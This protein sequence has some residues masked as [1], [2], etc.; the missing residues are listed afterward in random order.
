MQIAKPSKD[1][2]TWGKVTHNIM[3]VEGCGA[4]KSM[5]LLGDPME[6]L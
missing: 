4:P 6:F 2:K 5:E 1:D 3:E